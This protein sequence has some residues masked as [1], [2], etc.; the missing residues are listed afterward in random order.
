MVATEIPAC[1][2]T[3]LQCISSILL[4]MKHLGHTVLPALRCQKRVLAIKSFLLG[5]KTSGFKRTL[6]SASL[7]TRRL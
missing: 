4:F 7:I 5:I 2:Y 1:I 6:I 3:V